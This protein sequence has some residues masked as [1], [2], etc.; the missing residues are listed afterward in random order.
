M[1]R[2]SLRLAGIL[3]AALTGPFLNTPAA[4]AA[5]LNSLAGGGGGDMLPPEQAFHADAQVDGNAIKLNFHVAKGY[6]LY[7]GRIKVETD[8][9]GLTLG[10]PDLP[11]GVE[12]NDPYLGKITVYKHDFTVTQPF[13]MSQAGPATLTLHYQGCSDAAGVCYPP[14][15]QKVSLKLPASSASGNGASS[16]TSSGQSESLSSLAGMASD[17]GN[18]PL[19]PEQAFKPSISVKGDTVSLHWAIADGY[20]LYRDRIKVGIANADAKLVNGQIGAG[21]KKDDPT[22]GTV[23]VFHHQLDAKVD[24]ANSSGKPITLVVGYQGCASLG[25]CYPPMT[26][27]WTIDTAKGTATKLEKAPKATLTELKSIAAGNAG[28]TAASSSKET[29]GSSD[30][31]GDQSQTDVI[32]NQLKTG[33]LFVIALTFLGIGLLLAFTPCIF[34]MIPILAGIIAGQGENI[35]TRKAF[36]LS[37]V[38]VLAMA[39]TYTVAGVLAGLFGSNL[40]AAFQNPWILGGFAAIFVAL[41]ISMFGFFELQL[42]SS[43]QSKI[44]EVQNRQE[45]GTLVG[46]AVMGL[47]SA[48]IV[49]PCMA[50]PLAGALIY[51]GQTGDAFIGGTAL[52]AMSIGMGLPLI[53]VGTLGGKFLPRAGGWMDAVKAVFGVIMLGVA[54]WMLERVIPDIV[55][56]TLWGL[57]VLASAIYLGAL[58][59]VREEASGWK[60]LWKALGFV[61]LL[62]GSLILV[63]VAAGGKGT[64][65][66]PLSGLSFGGGGSGGATATAQ[67][68]TFK[69][70]STVQGLE[71]AL[72]AAKA[73]GKPVMLDFYADWCV[74]CKKME[75]DTFSDPTVISAMKPFVLLQADV[76]KNNDAD[77]ALLKRF[78]LFGPPG[79]IFFDANGKMLKAQEVVGFQ[80]P[81]TFIKHVKAAKQQP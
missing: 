70:V 29:S 31:S 61:M 27:A 8:T 56:Q 41:A 23:Y 37:L 26:T 7:Q 32:A 75:H 25:L 9:Q 72:A 53:I 2:P 58:E 33:N 65:L 22:F 38:Y 55:A 15:T 13:Q 60:K 64:V 48:L 59:P 17:S 68:L 66:T 44:M 50:P 76:T 54:I 24:I 36:V 78:G 6:H 51:I 34:P 77:K 47:L 21:E 18:E 49:G 43:V 74:E 69:Q 4:M 19:P 46:V 81:E 57:L 1:T 11:Q 52:F 30:S 79:I 39:V 14:Q 12:E 28:Q 20:Y 67:K 5:D 10:K 3:L 71:Q 40:Q 73:S 62:W 63:G 16:K 42:P 35:T 80:P 45:G